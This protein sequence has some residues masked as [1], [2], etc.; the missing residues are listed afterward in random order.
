M[1]AS[2]PMPTPPHTQPRRPGPGLG[3]SIGL[4]V[5]GAVIAIASA[6]AIAIPLVNTF[7]SS[8]Y[9]TPTHITIHLRHARYTVYE[10]TASS[11]GFR[12]GTSSGRLTIEPSQVG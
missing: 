12:F 8:A 5:L 6:I 9:A 1:T 11:S 4:M 2:L 7:T 3:I 10:R